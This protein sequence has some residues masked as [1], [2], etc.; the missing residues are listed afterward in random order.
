LV[1]GEVLVVLVGVEMLGVCEAGIYMQV[2]DFEARAA[3]GQSFFSLS[4]RRL[5]AEKAAFLRGK[6][7][8]C[9]ITTQEFVVAL[10]LF[11]GW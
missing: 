10:C 11:L 1:E 8:M 7:L 3:H 9:L 2:F 6:H 5:P 4:S